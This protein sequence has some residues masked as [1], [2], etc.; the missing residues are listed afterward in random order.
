MGKQCGYDY[1]KGY[2]FRRWFIPAYMMGGLER[3]IEQGI[4]PSDFLC[5][6]INNDLRSACD[7]ADDNN[8]ENLPAYMGFFYNEA[9]AG[10]WGF[11]GAVEQWCE[12][13][14]K[15]AQNG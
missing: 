12:K 7:R 8:L 2:S 4:P 3:Y 6:V 14:F 10:C 5:A 11:K 15:E 1:S 13:L 9:P